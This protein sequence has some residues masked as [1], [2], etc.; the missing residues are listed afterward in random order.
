MGFLRRLGSSIVH[1]PIASVVKEVVK[2]NPVVQAVHIIQHPVEAIKNPIK[3]I[4]SI[5]PIAV[6]AKELDKVVPI[7][8]VV[9]EAEKIV[10]ISQIIKEVKMV[11][12][13]VPVVEL[14]KKAEEKTL[15]AVKMA[16]KVPLNVGKAV[17]HTTEKAGDVVIKGAMSIEHKA[18]SIISSVG[19]GVGGLFGDIKWVLIGGMAIV[20]LVVAFKGKELLSELKK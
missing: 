15:E 1:N 18:E 16:G 4:T 10:P 9:K 7:S 8:H 5:T 13:P 3:T 12:P 11:I 17:I 6:V 20:G 19:H 14:F 2:V